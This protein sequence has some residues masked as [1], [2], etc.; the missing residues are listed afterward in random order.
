MAAEFIN[1]SDVNLAQ[2]ADGLR[3]GVRTMT[4]TSTSKQ[5]EPQYVSQ[6]F[7]VERQSTTAIG[8]ATF[9]QNVSESVRKYMNSSLTLANYN[10]MYNTNQYIN[11]NLETQ[12]KQLNEL[13]GK[14]RTQVLRMRQ[15]QLL[16]IYDNNAER[17]KNGAVLGALFVIA[18]CAAVMY[19]SLKHDP[20][21]LSVKVAGGICGAIVVVYL[22]VLMLYIANNRNRRR[23]DWNKYYFSAYKKAG[24]GDSSC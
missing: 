18:T 3:L 23:T 7:D 12:H 6:L 14:A 16:V 22:L 21:I 10:E 8:T 19:M 24:S 4:S 17:F 20:P 13:Q 1:Y 2:A 9:Q 5:F 11:S 15:R